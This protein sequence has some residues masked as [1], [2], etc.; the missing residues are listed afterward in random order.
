MGPGHRGALRVYLAWVTAFGVLQG[1]SAALMVPVLRGL[2]GG[3]LPAALSWLGVMAVAVAATCV[4]NYVQAMKGFAVAIT[5]LTSMHERVG[6]HVGTLPVGWFTTEK[7][8]RLSRMVTSGT[9]MVGG[10]FAHLLTPLVAG[11]VTPA[12]IALATFFFDWRLAV[13]M[14]V[15]APVMAVVFG[16]AG[17]L[18]GKGE[19]LSDAA[20]VTAANRVVELARHQR[21][22]RAFGRGAAGHRPLDDAITAQH[23]VGRRA[24]WLSVPGILAGGFATQLAFTVLIVTGVLLAP[25]STVDAVALVAVLALAARFTGPLAELSALAGAVRMARTTTYGGSPRCSTSSR[26]PSPPNAWN[27]RVLGRSSWPGSGSGTQRTG[28][29]CGTCRSPCRQG[30]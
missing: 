19:E 30:R 12:T 2:L 24:M 14:L 21:T 3:D 1:V 23:T 7:V 15:T 22:L 16:W 17:R 8:G 11:A 9:V 18:V 5:V 10:L 28:P 27:R 4:A 6:D 26:S 29:C 25:R 13:A 20:A